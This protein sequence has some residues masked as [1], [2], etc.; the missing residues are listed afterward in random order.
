[1]NEIQLLYVQNSIVRKKT[2]RPAQHLF[3][4]IRVQNLSFNKSIDVLWCGENGI[5][6]ILPATFHST[7][8][9]N[10]EY[11]LAAVQCPAG[12]ST[13]LPGNIEFVLR[14]RAAGREYW[15]H[16]DSRNYVSEADSGIRLAKNFSLLTVDYTSLLPNGQNYLAVTV[17]A[18]RSLR[19]EKVTV[20]WSADN[21]QTSRQA[22]CYCKGDYWDKIC[23]SNARNPNQ[24]GV[25]LWKGWLKVKTVF[26]LQYYVSCE[27]PGG[28][29]Y[30]NNGSVNYRV[31]RPPLKILILNLHCYQEDEQDAK[32]SRI[33]QAI[34]EQQADI[35]CLQEVAEF[36]NEGRGDFASNSAHIINSRL[37]SPFYLHHDWSHLGFERYKEGV[38]I[39]SRYPPVRQDSRYV[40]GD[41][42]VYSIH[43]RKVVMVQ[44][45]VPHIGCINVFSV[46]LSW[47]EDGFSG[48]F[49][50]LCAWAEAERDASVKASFLCGDFN[51][52]AGSEGYRL[53]V[54]GNQ[55]DDQFL[56]I[57]NRRAFEKV[58]RVDDAHW[59]HYLADDYRIDYIF[60]H[61]GSVLQALDGQVLF[62]DEDYGKVSDHCGYLISFEPGAT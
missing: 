29:V 1:M 5:W 51:V 35:V 48:Q 60:L 49:G 61:K 39:L 19:A 16:D 7:G 34:D 54:A 30:D 32:F 18:H 36:W 45:Q 26:R 50:N 14:Y 3:F 43:S 10:Q 41:Q 55:Y 20:H 62:T 44:I 9:P 23:A 8:A 40:S 25:Q 13:P 38:A 15:D 31:S 21:W 57:S 56:K 37:P 12:R 42:D 24:Y 53:V 2:S 47:W 59:Q 58:F 52:A 27:G 17:A 46:H 11:W 4:W 33:A 28:I 6:Q 22:R